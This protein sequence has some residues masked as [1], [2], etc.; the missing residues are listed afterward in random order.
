MIVSTRQNKFTLAYFEFLSYQLECCNS[1]NIL[2]Q[3][4]RPPLHSLKKELEDLIKSIASD[5]MTLDYMKKTAPSKIDS[6]SSAFHVPLIQIYV[7][8]AATATLCEMEADGAGET[9]S[10]QFDR[11]RTHCTDFLVEAILQIQKRFVLVAESEAKS[12]MSWEQY[13]RVIRDAKTV[14]GEQTYP[15]LM[16][17]VSIIALFLFQTQQ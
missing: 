3:S 6:T 8:M 10:E 1:F 15:S 17:F 5:F 7:G 9:Q 16:Q 2:F 13:W 14:T 12:E 4:T 11:F